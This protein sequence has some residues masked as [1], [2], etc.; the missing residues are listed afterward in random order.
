MN[1]VIYEH[2]LT[3]RLRLLLRLELLF[4]QFSQGV[5]G[6][7][8]WY[9]EQALL[10]LCD[11]HELAASAEPRAEVSKELDRQ[12]QV[13]GHL[14]QR[15]D[16]DRDALDRVLDE[17]DQALDGLHAGAS[18]GLP[19]RNPFLDSIRQRMSAAEGR[20]RSEPPLLHHWLHQHSPEERST[21]LQHWLAPLQPLQQGTRLVLDLL[22]GSVIPRPCVA[23]GGRYQ[24]SND[25]DPL[26]LLLRLEIATGQP[27]YPEISGN[28]QRFA[29]RFM[30]HGDPDQGPES[31][32]EDVEFRL[33]CCVI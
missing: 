22:R 10:A 6:D 26:P 18:P 2:P 20:C 21:Q 32:T 29:V 16:I 33:A 4:D 3:D 14:Q 17:I 15:S 24:Q 19:R 28:R 27:V 9:S 11:L 25:S 7:S 12:G 31:I 13:F 5:A 30:R 8:E 1:H 23:D